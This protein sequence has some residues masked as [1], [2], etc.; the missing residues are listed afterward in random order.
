MKRFIF[1][2]GKSTE[3]MFAFWDFWQSLKGLL[4]GLNCFVFI[5]YV[6]VSTTVP[7]ILA[8]PE[9]LLA[10]WLVEWMD[11]WMRDT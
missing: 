9:L 10:G 11:E 6:V 7:G 8:G 4:W 5:K 2:K 1:E 3:I